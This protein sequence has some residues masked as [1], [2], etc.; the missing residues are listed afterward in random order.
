MKSDKLKLTTYL[1][2]VLN[3]KEI[4]IGKEKINAILDLRVPK[5]VG[6]LQ[7][8]I[9]MLV[10]YSKLIKNY[11]D[12]MYPLYYLLRKNPKFVW[13]KKCQSAFLQAK[14]RLVS[15]DVL[16]YYDPSKPVKLTCD[17]SLMG[18]GSVLA[19]IGD[20]GTNRPI[21]F[22]SRTLTKAEFNYSQLD[23]EAL[24]MVESVKF[25]DY[26]LNGL[27]FILKTD[28]KQLVYIVGDKKGIPVIA[29]SQNSKLCFSL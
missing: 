29:A 2:Y 20:D 14:E 4:A 11:A 25:F 5:K 17:A 7:I 28:H 22:F 12:L 24:S 26:I 8:F 1:G 16:V 10:Y 19:H 13:N 23:R 6:E 3:D 21:A 18:I 15:H 27:E 9:G